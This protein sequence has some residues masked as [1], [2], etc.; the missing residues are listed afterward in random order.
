MLQEIKEEADINQEWQNIK[1]VILDIATEFQLAR[2]VKKPNHWWD[3]ECKKAIQEKNEAR[4]ICLI[5]KTRANRDNYRQKRTKANRP[6]RRKK[7]KWLER[8]IKEI[9]ESN[10]KKDTRK[11]YKDIGNLSHPP[12]TTTLVCK[13]KDGKILSDERQTFERWQ[14][15]FKELLDF[16]NK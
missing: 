6:C 2:G 16:E 1:Q 11:F 15:Y 5:R 12:I 13:D 4:R 7:K 9:S 3:D 14:Q 10:R 8:K